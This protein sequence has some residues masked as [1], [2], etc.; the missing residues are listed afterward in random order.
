MADLKCPFCGGDVLIKV[1]DLEGNNR[2]EPG[3]KENP[4]SGLGFKLWHSEDEDSTNKCPIATFEGELGTLIYSSEELAIKAWNMRASG[5][6]PCSERLPADME[7]VLT[8]DKHGNINIMWHYSK[9]EVPFNIS[10]NHIAY[11]PVIAWMP[12]PDPYKEEE[13]K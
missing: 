13:V 3:Y 9:F 1:C 8:C 12:L 10:E 6:I 11:Y 5:W 7:N 4:W 2:D